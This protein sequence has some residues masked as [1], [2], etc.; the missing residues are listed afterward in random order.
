MNSE[1]LSVLVLG[2]IAGR[3]SLPNYHGVDLGRCLV[4]PRRMQVINRSV[5]DGMCE[6]STETVWLVLEEDPDKGDGYKIVFNEQIGMFGLAIRGFESDAHPVL[7]GYYG[8]FPT[9]L[10]A[11]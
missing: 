11:M 8:D 6:D 4:P 10:E 2:Q 9:T 1:D 3:E 7:C 5:R